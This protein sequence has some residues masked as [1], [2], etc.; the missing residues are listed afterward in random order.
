M[1]SSSACW[2]KKSFTSIRVASVT[3]QTYTKTAAP[4]TYTTAPVPLATLLPMGTSMPDDWEDGDEGTDNN[5]A[6]K[7]TA[8]HPLILIC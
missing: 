1:E 5:V 8:G 4:V 6:G 2:L 7:K 3:Y